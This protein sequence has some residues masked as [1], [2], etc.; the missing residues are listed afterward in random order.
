MPMSSASLA[1]SG[2][3]PPGMAGSGPRP[4][5]PLLPAIRHVLAAAAGRVTLRLA[6]AGPLTGTAHRR[7]ATMALLQDAALAGGGQVFETAA[8]DLLLLATAAPAAERAA[9][10][11]ARLSAEAAP[12]TWTLPADNA[13][14]LAWAETAR[15]S[16]PMP[17]GPAAP[18]PGP[19]GLDALLDALP[20]HRVVRRQ[21]ILW[22]AAGAAP[23]LAARRLVVCRAALRAVLGAL[24]PDPDLLR[25]A[26]DRIAARLSGDRTAVH[27]SGDWIAARSSGPRPAA[28]QGP[29]GLAADPAALLLVPLPLHGWPE[30]THGHRPEH[31]PPPADR[32][33][34]GLVSRTGSRPGPS[35]G[36]IGVLPLAAA[37]DPAALAQRRAALAAA[38]WGLALSGLDAAALRLVTPALLAADLLLLRWSPALA[39]RAATAALRSG[40]KGKWPSGQSPGARPAGADRLRWAGGDGVGPLRRHPPL[41]RAAGGGAAGGVP[42]GGL[43]GRRGLQ[44]RAMRRPRRGDRPRQ[45]SRVRQPGTAGGAAAR[46]R[47]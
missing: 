11:L 46:R 39:D 45:P 38:G 5:L 16:P 17:R 2:T 29:V 25:H 35:L 24:A 37:A 7:R 19:A 22:H 47:P 14:L 32:D 41:R 21:A 13:L 1:Q 8:G 42:P 23:A 44:P 9:A 12:E 33:A 27:S 15:L 36:L 26:E 6:P 40:L 3:A 31:G 43:P 10:L 28:G 20:L 34:P 4:D 30:P 18:A